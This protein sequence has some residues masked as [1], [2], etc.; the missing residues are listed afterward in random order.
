M[1][2]RTASHHGILAF[3]AVLVGAALLLLPA[4]PARADLALVQGAVVRI[5]AKGQSQRVG[6]GVLVARQND[7]AYLL[8]AEH[9]VRGAAT[10]EVEF[11]SDPGK[12]HRAQVVAVEEMGQEQN[13]RALALLTVTDDLPPRALAVRLYPSSRLRSSEPMHLI[14]F[15]QRAGGSWTITQASLAAR[16]DTLVLSA[17]ADSGSS[18]GPVVQGERVVGLVT[19][20]NGPF[21]FARPAEE[22]EQFLVRHGVPAPT[23]AAGIAFEEAARLWKLG[24]YDEVLPLVRK[25]A[26]GRDNR[27]RCLL[28]MAL[29][30]LER[31]PDLGSIDAWD[32][33]E[34]QIGA[35][36]L[37]R[38]AA[39]SGDPFGI[40]TQ[41]IVATFIIEEG[42]EE[43]TAE[44]IR[45]LGYES[46]P[47]LIAREVGSQEFRGEMEKLRTRHPSLTPTEL[48]DLLDPGE[49]VMDRIL[50]EIIDRTVTVISQHVPDK[51]A[52]SWSV[53][54][55]LFD[56]EEILSDDEPDP[57][58]RLFFTD[59]A[60]GYIASAMLLFF[61]QS[62]YEDDDAKSLGRVV[63]LVSAS[64]ATGLREAGR[65][66]CQMAIRHYDALADSAQQL[67]KGCRL[68]AEA[69]DPEA[70]EL[71]GDLYA[72]GV[73]GARN[74][75][76]AMAWYKLAAEAG[77]SYAMVKLGGIYELGLADGSS[78][79]YS[80]DKWYR[81]ALAHDQGH[82][83]EAVSLLLVG[84]PG[85]PK[86]QTAAIRL[87]IQ[88]LGEFVAQAWFDELFLP[89]D[90]EGNLPQPQLG[91]SSPPIRT[92]ELRSPRVELDSDVEI[93]VLAVRS[94]GGRDQSIRYTI[95]LD[96]DYSR[97]F[98]RL[99]L[100][101]GRLL[102]SNLNGRDQAARWY[103][104]AAALGD[105]EASEA[106]RQ[107]GF[108]MPRG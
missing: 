40:W 57:F 54:W 24:V 1:I 14:G 27:A 79:F 41:F 108:A 52:E 58:R 90:I 26:D 66:A 89:S 56:D 92:F 103:R 74:Y 86:D 37:A 105:V 85:T 46:W 47:A 83:I 65:L 77:Q 50:S 31:D 11:D 84:A 101:R 78:D 7:T 20:M 80:A 35:W 67:L 55:L 69:R 51:P 9:V 29:L 48:T 93:R 18:G 38:D 44:V 100:Q 88:N 73:G 6:A 16:Q 17:A 22:L 43:L 2:H 81:Q 82:V 42:P 3:G 19:E 23:L 33:D 95:R 68:S 70:M 63:P 91:S 21:V 102:E 39:T 13:N 106:L 98:A 45:A 61:A 8:T 5:T 36:Q 10:I 72:A 59:L 12:P 64:A 62:F 87:L 94:L 30:G 49:R 4:A 104:R 15:P 97:Q 28:A 71:L 53:P 75:R 34:D 25:A 99:M 96:E 76:S 32:L 60:P 107:L